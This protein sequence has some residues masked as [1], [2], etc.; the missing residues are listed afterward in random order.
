MQ[1]PKHK[2]DDATEE[3]GGEEEYAD[4]RYQLDGEKVYAG[5]G[6]EPDGVA[7]NRP[8]PVKPNG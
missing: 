8:I 4:G 1:E 5:Y 6:D 3:H 7:V 2:A